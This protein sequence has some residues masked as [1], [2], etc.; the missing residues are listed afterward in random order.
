MSQVLTVPTHF[1]DLGELSEGFLDRVEQDTLILYGPVAYEDGSEIEFVVLLADGSPAL[2][3]VGRVRAAVD[4]GADRVPETR[5]D[6]VVEALQL[7]GRSEVVFER[8]VLAR[9][10][11]SDHPPAHDAEPPTG[12]IDV[13]PSDD[14]LSSE[15]DTV[16]PDEEEPDT[17]PPTASDAPDTVPPAASD[18]DD[19]EE[20]EYDDEPATVI[21]AVDA[22]AM[23]V[24]AEAVSE[25]EAATEAATV[26][27]SE[28]ATEA[29]SE[30]VPV[31]EPA[32]ELEFGEEDDV[33]VEA[34][35]SD[36]SDWDEEAVASDELASDEEAAASGELA[37]DEEAAA[38][39]EGEFDSEYAFEHGIAAEPQVGMP[40]PIPSMAAPPE[41]PPAPPTLRLAEPPDGL[42]RPSL[43]QAEESAFTADGE[44]SDVHTT[45][46]FVYENGLP[47]PSRPPLP[48]LNRPRSAAPVEAADGYDV[49]ESEP[50]E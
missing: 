2:E 45:G 39:E 1:N 14:E 38:S 26:A 27:V 19:D 9:Q 10:A 8:L 28:P 25:A 5:Y 18:E 48:D 20:Y 36:A 21:A 33:E 11:V 46:L 50:P 24:E 42:T 47:I 29:A 7:D 49:E 40:V 3:G 43:A 6:V 30:S 34:T 23:M 12:D 31:S 4:G 22:E 13:A 37:P 44:V 16:P 41:A 32:P 15:P 17:V 35:M